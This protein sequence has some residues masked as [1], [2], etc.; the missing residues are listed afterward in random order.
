M[1]HLTC[2]SRSRP[3]LDQLVVRPERAIEQDKVGGPAR[4]LDFLC[5]PLDIG[6]DHDRAAGAEVLDPEADAVVIHL[7]LWSVGVSRRAAVGLDGPY[8]QTRLASLVVEQRPIVKVG[9]L[10]IGS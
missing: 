8:D 7:A 1:S 5:P 6:K 9:L 2:R 4:L 10:P 3:H